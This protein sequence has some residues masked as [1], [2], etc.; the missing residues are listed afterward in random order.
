MQYT[1]KSSVTSFLSILFRVKGK[2]H[3]SRSLCSCAVYG[4]SEKGSIIIFGPRIHTNYIISLYISFSLLFIV[5]QCLSWCNSWN[6]QE[7]YLSSILM[8]RI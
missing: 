1:G 8:C 4:S 2:E 3:R 6:E 5:I 7:I